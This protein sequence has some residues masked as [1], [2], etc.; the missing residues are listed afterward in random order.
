M[1]PSRAEIL[2]SLADRI[3]EIESSGRPHDRSALALGIEALDDCLP[4]RRLVPGAL[5]EL[6]ADAEGAGVWTLALTMAR[7]ACGEWKT[8]VVTDV[9]GSFYPPAALKAGVDLERLIVVRPKARRDAYV[10]ARQAL[11]CTAVGAVLGW[12]DTLRTTDVRRLQVAAEAGGGMGLLL[13]PA[14]AA[15]TPSFAA[16]RLG[17]TP[18]A[19]AEASRRLRVEVLRCPGGKRGR[20]VTLEID[21][22][23][24]DVRVPAGLVPATARARAARASG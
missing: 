15:R 10:A 6:L 1:S 21:D 14:G 17:I 8:L 23:T 13:R 4:A 2:R 20:V 19:T 5:V 18:V 9:Q 22:E 16:L 11:R 12:H 3:Q 7:Q 24:G